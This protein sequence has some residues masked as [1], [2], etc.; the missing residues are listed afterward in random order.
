[1]LAREQVAHNDSRSSCHIMNAESD[2]A[3]GQL[4][5]ELYDSVG[6]RFSRLPTKLGVEL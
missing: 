2:A 3:T 6:R 4:V 1:V 5:A